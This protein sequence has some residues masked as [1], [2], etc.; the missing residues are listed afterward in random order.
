MMWRRPAC[1]RRGFPGERRSSSDFAAAPR[2]VER[3]PHRGQYVAGHR[4]ERSR[5]RAAGSIGMATSAEA[6]GDLAHIHVPL[7]AQTHLDVP[8]ELPEETGAAQGTDRA[9][10]L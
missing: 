2:R 4:L 10:E 9:G 3:D 1:R 8:A 5:D 6:R 7:A